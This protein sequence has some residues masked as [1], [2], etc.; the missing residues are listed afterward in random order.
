MCRSVLIGLLLF[1]IGCLVDSSTSI[2]IQVSQV[3]KPLQGSFPLYVHNEKRY[4]GGLYT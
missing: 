4:V 1:G 3:Y 2:E